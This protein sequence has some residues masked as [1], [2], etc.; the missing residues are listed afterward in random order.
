MIVVVGEALMDLIVGDDRSVIASPGGGPFN[1]AR[2]MGRL[3]SDVWL[4]GRISADPFGRILAKKL[5]KDGVKLVLPEPVDSPSAL[6]VVEIEDQRHARYWF[7]VENTAALML[8]ILLFSMNLKA[9]SR[10][11]TSAR[12]DWLSNPWPP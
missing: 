1:T 3:G 2:A 6:A 5:K 10:P 4:L 9:R 11:C 8:Q 7:H 12:S